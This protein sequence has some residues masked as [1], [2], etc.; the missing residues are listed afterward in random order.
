MITFIAQVGKVELY[1]PLPK[2][3]ISADHALA[4]VDTRKILASWKFIL[5]D[6]IAAKVILGPPDERLS[7]PAHLRLRGV[8]YVLSHVPT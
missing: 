6:S 1:T 7:L 4:R 3:S 5:L 8:C 2:E